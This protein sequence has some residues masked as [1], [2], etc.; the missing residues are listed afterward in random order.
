MALWRQRG[1]LASGCVALLAAAIACTAGQA[2]FPQQHAQAVGVTQVAKL[3]NPRI[4]CFATCVAPTAF[5][6][7]A[8]G[9]VQR[10]PMHHQTRSS[11]TWY[12]GSA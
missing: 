4:H 11:G 12:C 8:A 10:A 6:V 2:T 5:Y 3:V 9:V 1:L 7:V